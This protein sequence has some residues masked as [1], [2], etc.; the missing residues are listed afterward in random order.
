MVTSGNE[1]LMQENETHLN[2]DITRPRKAPV[3]CAKLEQTAVEFMNNKF[4]KLCGGLDG[5]IGNLQID[6][7]H[8]PDLTGMPIDMLVVDLTRAGENGGREHEESEEAEI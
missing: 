2:N 4:I 7:N 8:Q 5:V 3:N 6:Q 1:H